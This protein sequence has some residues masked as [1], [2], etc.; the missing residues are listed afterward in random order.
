LMKTGCLVKF[1]ELMDKNAR[2]HRP[3]RPKKLEIRHE[4]ELGSIGRIFQYHRKSAIRSAGL[5]R[6]CPRSAW[7]CIVLLRALLRVVA[8][9]FFFFC[10]FRVCG[11]IRLE[12][13]K[14]QTETHEGGRLF[15]H[16]PKFWV[17]RISEFAHT[18]HVQVYFLRDKESMGNE[19]V[20]SNFVWG[21]L[22]SRSRSPLRK[23]ICSP[24]VSIQCQVYLLSFI[25]TL[26]NWE[27]SCLSAY[28]SSELTN[29]LTSS[30]WIWEYN[31]VHRHTTL[32]YW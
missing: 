30:S 32:K 22:Q 3:W 17:D 26:L 6:A 27:Q 19:L 13:D 25:K 28:L 11:H 2:E 23:C 7:R 20:D 29:M 21:I 9:V 14:P 5:L 31:E 15:R 1:F 24:G 8:F 10:L 12:K 16:F 18:W 4:D